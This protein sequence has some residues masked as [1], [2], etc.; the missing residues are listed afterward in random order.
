[1]I[2]RR[3]QVIFDDGILDC[4]D[5][6]TWITHTSIAHTH[7]DIYIYICIHMY[8]CIYLY[9]YDVYIYI[10]TYTY[11]THTYIHRYIYL[12]VY[13]Y[14]SIRN[15]SV[16]IKHSSFFPLRVLW[17]EIPNPYCGWS[18]CSP[19]IIAI[20]L[21]KFPVPVS[22]ISPQHIRSISHSFF[23]GQHPHS[24]PI[25]VRQPS[26]RVCPFWWLLNNHTPCCWWDKDIFQLFD[27]QQN[28]NWSL[29]EP[30]VFNDWITLKS[31]NYNVGWWNRQSQ[32]WMRASTFFWVYL[33][34]FFPNF[35]LLQ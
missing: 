8:I 17:L 23:G 18:S 24:S 4:Q 7:T 33:D 5:T 26:N 11:R 14:I 21:G 34:N 25:L 9:M 13:L 16:L 12:Y 1:M 3:R 22:S 20:R 19:W 2:R 28:T 29:I 27:T 6:H 15:I 32:F 31:L 30:P 10:C 35:L